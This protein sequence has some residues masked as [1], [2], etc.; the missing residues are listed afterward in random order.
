M[1]VY[2]ACIVSILCVCFFVSQVH[3]NNN[4]PL[5]ESVMCV[6]TFLRS[7]VRFFIVG[8]K[9][10]SLTIERESTLMMMKNDDDDDVYAMRLCVSLFF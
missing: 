8:M 5:F 9:K 6:Y 2:C 3:A 4:F 1:C 10:N 7:I